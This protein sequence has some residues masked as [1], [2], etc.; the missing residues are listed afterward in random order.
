[1][2]SKSIR[3]LSLLLTCLIMI[4]QLSLYSSAAVS[5]D[6]LEGGTYRIRNVA[7]GLYMGVYVYNA[8]SA[9]SA[10]VFVS[11]YDA[12]DTGE[13]YTVERTANDCYRLIPQNDKGK[14][15]VSYESGTEAGARITKKANWGMECLFDITPVGDGS[16]T[17]APSTGDNIKAVIEVG[18]EKSGSD[19]YLQTA[20]YEKGNKNQFWVFESVNTTGITVAYTQTSVKL[21]STGKFYAA[22]QPSG[23]NAA[24]ALWSSS[25]E[26]VLLVGENGDYCA[27]GTGKATVYVTADGFLNSFKVEVCDSECFTWYS[28]NSVSGSDW[29]ASLLTSQYWYA[30]G[31]RK[32]YMCDGASA[33]NYTN[34]M[35]IGCAVCS[36]AMV[37]HNMGATMTEGYDFR[38]G[39]K[40]NL[41]ADPY[42]VSL[43]NTGNTNVLS[44]TQTV[45]GNPCYLAWKYVSDRF[46]VDGE[47]L[48]C[49]KVYTQNK[50]TIKEMLDI[51][52]QGVIA[53]LTRG[54]DSH[55]VV[56]AK[57]LNP[58]EKKTANLQFLVYDPAGYLASEGDGIP[59][60]DS[61]SVTAMHYLYSYISAI[62][63]Y[64]TADVI[65]ARYGK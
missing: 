36:V 12:K 1:L 50:K 51:H 55:Y 38:T 63:V 35:D 7:S 20:D 10:R 27:L 18:T 44:A 19:Y 46:F 60:V 40:G 52:P 6:R 41:V 49:T 2:K 47:P 57:C 11:K 58:N 62:V 42:T 3:L 22:L 5:Y 37:L 24:H 21:Y 16:F 14:Y 53:Q 32:R 39:Q 54:A 13:L 34:W 26:S 9:V 59:W 25:D 65:A 8:K 48:S 43:A 28:Q 15:A 4:P 33:S 17:I 64:D 31:V 61:I 56:F 45:Y 30:D 23:E 29:D